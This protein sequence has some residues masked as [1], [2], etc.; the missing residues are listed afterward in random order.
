MASARRMKK[1]N[2]NR[3][4]ALSKICEAVLHINGRE[5]VIVAISDGDSVTTLTVVIHLEQK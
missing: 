2:K 4:T 5:L 3:A 1:M